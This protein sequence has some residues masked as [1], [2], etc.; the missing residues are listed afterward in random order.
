[1][2]QVAQVGA[3]LAANRRD[4]TSERFRSA[5]WA[6]A[7]VAMQP[8]PQY[9]AEQTAEKQKQCGERIDACRRS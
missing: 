8:Y 3:L 9:R 2:L 5:E 1:M 4:A 6:A 7:K